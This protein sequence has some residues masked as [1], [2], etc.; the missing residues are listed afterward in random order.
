LD[1]GAARARWVGQYQ[2]SGLGLKQFAEK[3]GLSTG[4]L[5]YWVYGLPQ[6]RRGPGSVPVF[7]EVRLAAAVTPPAPWSAEV[8]LSDG[9]TVRLVRGVDVAWTLSLVEGLRRP[10][11]SH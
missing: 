7:R 2:A 5:R 1:R 4:Q 10:C 3:H 8:G 6:R 9:T 11:S